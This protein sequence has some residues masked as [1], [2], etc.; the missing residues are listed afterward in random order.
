MCARKLKQTGTDLNVV[1]TD[2]DSIEWSLHPSNQSR[3]DT[4]NSYV[5]GHGFETQIEKSFVA[6]IEVLNSWVT[7]PTVFTQKKKVT[8]PNFVQGYI[9]QSMGNYIWYYELYSLNKAKV[10]FPFVQV[11]E[12]YSLNLHPSYNYQI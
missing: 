10:L 7:W 12:L 2:L 6:I 11:N 8:N 5:R 4:L 1:C 9:D 3:S